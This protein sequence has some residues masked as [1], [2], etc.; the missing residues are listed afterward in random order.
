MSFDDPEK[1]IASLNQSDIDYARQ[2]FNNEVEHLSRV[3]F[4]KTQL[5]KLIVD[6]MKNIEEKQQM[7]LKQLITA[8]Q[9]VEEFH[10][11]QTIEALNLSVTD[12]LKRKFGDK[13]KSDINVKYKYDD[14]EGSA[15]DNY[16]VGNCNR[17]SVRTE[18]KI[19]ED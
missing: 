12:Q 8:M 14:T 13:Y 2:K 17:S 18:L 10:L 1:I 9:R 16:V 3:D 7:Q 5:G 6:L 11:E 4:Y 15:M 19:L